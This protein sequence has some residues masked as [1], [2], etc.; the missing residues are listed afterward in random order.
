METN[1]TRVLDSFQVS[2]H[3]ETIDPGN[4]MLLWRTNLLV[5]E[6]KRKEIVI[7]WSQ[8]AAMRIITRP[9][10]ASTASQKR[11]CDGVKYVVVS[12]CIPSKSQRSNLNLVNLG[13]MKVS[14]SKGIL[15]ENE[16]RFGIGDHSFENK[17]NL[18]QYF[19]HGAL[20]RKESANRF[21]NEWKEIQ[22][23][24]RILY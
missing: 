6:S 15:G 10:T 12:K 20:D 14:I 3:S 17:P 21:S 7:E 8:P 2:I 16:R 9:A 19:V 4:K 18:Y 5:L 1:S 11:F 13:R 22:S 24:R 23:S